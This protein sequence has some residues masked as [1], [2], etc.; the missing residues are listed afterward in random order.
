MKKSKSIHSE[1]LNHNSFFS[2]LVNHL[3]KLP[4]VTRFKEIYLFLRKYI[5]VGRLLKITKSIVI[6]LQAGTFF[7]LYASVILVF[8]PPV[9]MLLLVVFF[10]R[11]NKYRIYNR[12]FAE[13]I[14]SFDFYVV[15]IDD[16]ELSVCDEQLCSKDRITLFVSENPTFLLP[17]IIK[18]INTNCF[19][20]C[21]SY[22]YYLNKHII[23]KN[24][25]KVYF[26]SEEEI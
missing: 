1:L 7:I 8:I 25:S 23:N 15:F 5:L 22:Y 2:Y 4:L 24:K 14:K 12:K 21:T 18:R 3:S 17:K 26:I 10:V 16:D 13:L 20:I 6:F 11:Y 19:F 9:V